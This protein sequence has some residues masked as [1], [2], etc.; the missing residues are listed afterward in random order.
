MSLPRDFRR[1]LD[2][3]VIAVRDRPSPRMLREMGEESLLGVYVGTPLTER[4]HDELFRMPDQILLFQRPIEEMCRS[5]REIVEQVRIT[6]VHEV[7]H[8]F[9]LDDDEIEAI[10]GE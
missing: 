6:V 10:L 7:G 8:F 2:N 3:L 9:G 5:E 4:H 1:R